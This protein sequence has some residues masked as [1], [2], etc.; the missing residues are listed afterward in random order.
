MLPTE[1][2]PTVTTL[3][4]AQPIRPARWIL[5]EAP[6]EEA[7]KDLSESLSLP[8]VVCR[9]LLIRGYVS[10]EDAKLFLRPKLD[11]LHD[12][13]LVLSMDKAVDRVPRGGGK[14]GLGVI[15][16]GADV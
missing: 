15:Q 7:V 4:S 9:L 2:E 1:R 12:P 14:Q 10:A 8:E 5:P 13:L 16:C 3:A 11:K 6:D